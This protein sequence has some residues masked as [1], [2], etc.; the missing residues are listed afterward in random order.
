MKAAEASWLEFK[1]GGEIKPPRTDGSR[2]HSDSVCG[3]FTQK[4]PPLLS[5]TTHLDGPASSTPTAGAPLQCM[6]PRPASICEGFAPGRRA[7]R[8]GGTGQ[9][10]SAQPVAEPLLLGFATFEFTHTSV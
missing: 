3:S 2:A 5:E 8:Q 10:D 9:S 6:D 7:M 4:P 1:Q